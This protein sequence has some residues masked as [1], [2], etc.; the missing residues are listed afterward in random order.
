MITSLPDAYGRGR[1]I[2]YYRR[3]ALYGVDRLIAEKKKKKA[4]LAEATFDT[5]QIRQDEKI[6]QQISFM[7]YRKKTAAMYG[8]DIRQP[9]MP[10]RPSSGRDLPIWAPSRSITVPSCCWAA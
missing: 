7:D 2:G 8:F 6:Y 5:E 10:V 9:S 1:I 3:G 4:K